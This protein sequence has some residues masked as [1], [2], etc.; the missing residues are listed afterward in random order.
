MTALLLALSLSVDALGIGISYGLRNIKTPFPAKLMISFLSFTIT[1]IAILCGNFIL[2]FLPPEI[3]KWGGAIML[4]SLGVFVV[5]SNLLKKP[6][7][8]DADQSQHIDI[9]EAFFLGIALSIDSFGTG[10]CS[11]VMGLNSLYIPLMVALCQLLFLWGGSILGKKL[12]SVESL[13]S[14]V[15]TVLSGI[16]LIVIALIRL[17]Y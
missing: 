8:Y 4:I 11:A 3:A 6:E 14:G 15:F 9:K 1:A 16:L 13:P 7:G 12:R 2:L 5:F 17:Y 10:I